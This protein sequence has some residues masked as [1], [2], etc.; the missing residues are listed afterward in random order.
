MQRLIEKIIFVISISRFFVSLKSVLV[1]QRGIFSQAIK[2]HHY[3]RHNLHVF[4]THKLFAM[5]YQMP[6]NLKFLLRQP[7]KSMGY[8]FI[9]ANDITNIIFLQLFWTSESSLLRRLFRPLHPHVSLLLLL[10][11]KVFTSSFFFIFAFPLEL[12]SKT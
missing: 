10:K 5:G 8:F 9:F 12:E 11:R 6:N 2:M 1:Q 3:K 7:L 4:L